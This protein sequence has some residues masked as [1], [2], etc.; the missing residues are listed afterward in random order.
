MEPIVLISSVALWILVI[1]NL[2]LTFALVNR[3]NSPAKTSV[4]MLP[5]GELVPNL[6]VETLDGQVKTLRDIQSSRKMEMALVFVSP[7]CEPCREHMPELDRL[8]GKAQLAGVEL[9]PISLSDKKTTQDFVDAVKFTSPIVIPFGNET[10]INTDFKVKGTPSYY[11]I[12]IKGRVKQ[13]GYLDK[14]WRN[15]VERWS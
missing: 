7:Y 1:F 12:D 10:D 3:V 14:N 6:T 9:M 4:D 13:A 8:Y 15:L 11:L 2:L 5:V